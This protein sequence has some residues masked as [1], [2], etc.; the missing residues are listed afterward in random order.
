MRGLEVLVVAK[1]IKM[2]KHQVVGEHV[3]YGREE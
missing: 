1:M 2:L 3:M